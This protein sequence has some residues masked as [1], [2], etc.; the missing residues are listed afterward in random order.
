MNI[1]SERSSLGQR[2]RWLR[3]KHR[4]TLKDFGQIVHATE[5][6]LS[7]LERDHSSNPSLRLVQH[8]CQ[9]FSVREQW[10][11][12]GAGEPFTLES[13][14]EVARSPAAIVTIDLK[15]SS[16]TDA[17]GKVTLT[18]E[19]MRVMLGGR[20]DPESLLESLL[21]FLKNP[22]YPPAVSLETAKAVAFLF[23]A[24]RKRRKE[25]AVLDPASKSENSSLLTSKVSDTIPDVT[26]QLP[27]LLERLRK[28]TRERGKKLVLAKHLGVAPAMVSQWLSEDRE[29]GG[30]T[31]LRMLRWVE[32]QEQQ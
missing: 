1:A 2:L 3:K 6:Y 18:P 27:S 17:P 16:T 29:P 14:N 22:P 13:L 10:L 20:G 8:I 26:K 21:S 24:A 30:E 23:E 15:S 28:A 12:T 7:K 5:S 32:L 9:T 19:L 11:L 4:L 31:A 25:R